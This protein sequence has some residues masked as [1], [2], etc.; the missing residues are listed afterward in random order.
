MHIRIKANWPVLGLQLHVKIGIFV[1][2]FLTGAT[3]GRQ[4]IADLPF[5]NDFSILKIRRHITNIP[6]SVNEQST[7]E[8][9]YVAYAYVANVKQRLLIL[10]K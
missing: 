9:L 3:L 1:L 5:E 7:T 10:L 6:W 2:T 4:P 8:S